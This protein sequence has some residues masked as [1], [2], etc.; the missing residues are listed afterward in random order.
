MTT[1][2]MMKQTAFAELAAM[3]EP[4]LPV[5]LL[6]D[7]SGSMQGQPMAD[8]LEG[9]RRFLEIDEIGRAHV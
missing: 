8:L 3:S 9:Y 2:T 6:L 4:R 5:L 1:N 7:T